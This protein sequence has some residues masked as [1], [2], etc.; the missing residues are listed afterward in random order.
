MTYGQAE[1]LQP[2]LTNPLFCFAP[3]RGPISNF[4]PCHA[5]RDESCIRGRPGTSCELIPACDR[6]L[7]IAALAHPAPADSCIHARQVRFEVQR[8]A[9]TRIS[10]TAPVRAVLRINPALLIR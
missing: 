8:T 9:E 7:R 1:Y 10:L 3:H 6:S 4:L 5:A 2:L